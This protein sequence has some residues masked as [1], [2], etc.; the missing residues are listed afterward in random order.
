MIYFPRVEV[1]HPYKEIVV[2]S[3]DETIHVIIVN[4]GKSEAIIYFGGNAEAAGYSAQAY[5]GYFPEQTL[6]FV[7]YR[8]YGKSSGSPTQDAL[9]RDALHVYDAIKEKHSVVHAAGRSLGSSIAIYLAANREI[10]RLALITP[11][12]SIEHIAKDQLPFYPV[13]WFLKDRYDSVSYVP[14]V[15]ATDT[16]ILSAEEDKIVNA[17][18]TQKLIEAF[19][20]KKLHTEVIKEKGHNSISY[21]PKYF[22]VLK[23]YFN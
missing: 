4:E 17:K 10:N 9:Y 7:N 11:F 16:L 5:D 22:E 21:D 14:D 2:Q 1:S 6:Y 23:A 3:G 19:G 18:Y 13:S 12:D 8:S 20:D 15:S